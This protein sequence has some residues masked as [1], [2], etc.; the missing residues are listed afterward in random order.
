[1]LVKVQLGT[2]AEPSETPEV[3][4]NPGR[5]PSDRGLNPSSST[6]HDTSYELGTASKVNSCVAS[7]EHSDW[8][9]TSRRML[10]PGNT[11]KL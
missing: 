2:V 8:D 11:S 4:V 3:G 1:M 7:P 6:C 9:D 10:P 5:S